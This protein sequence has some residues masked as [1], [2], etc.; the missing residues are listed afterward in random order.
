[1]HSLGSLFRKKYPTFAAWTKQWNVFLLV[2]LCM[3]V[4]YAG[5]E[6]LRR[7]AFELHGPENYD[8]SM[9]WAVGRGIVNGL[10]PYADLF[11]TKPPGIFLLSALSLSLFDSRILGSIV[12]AISL[13]IIAL[14]P[15]FAIVPPA[16][17]RR[18]PN[19]A[20]RALVSLLFGC[21]LL[22]FVAER[23]G[24]YQVESFATAWAMLF[25]LIIGNTQRP[26]TWRRIVLASLCLL[27]SVGF[28][29]QL[30]LSIL[31][32]AIVL[33][34]SWNTFFRAF[35]LPFLLAAVIGLCALWALGYTW[36]FF[37]IY[38]PEMLGR[39]IHSDGFFLLKAFR[40]EKILA[41]MTN[42][43]SFNFFFA[44]SMAYLILLSLIHP[45]IHCPKAWQSWQFLLR[46]LL[47]IL[48]SIGGVYLGGK[49]FFPHHYTVIVP[50]LFC[51]FLLVAQKWNVSLPSPYLQVLWLP[52]VVLLLLATTAIRHPDYEKALKKNREWTAPGKAMAATVDT[53]LTACKTERYLYIGLHGPKLF[54]Y[55]THSPL[56]PLFYQ[57]THYLSPERASFRSAFHQSLERAQ[58]L[59]LSKEKRE[60]NDMDGE[61]MDHIKEHFTTTPWTCAGGD[62]KSNDLYE[63]YF[64]QQKKSQ[65][66]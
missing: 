55:T 31:A 57:F 48:L 17:W 42:L 36:P 39:H 41:I 29:E 66:L 47:G 18:N 25:I 27:F 28:K 33:S 62:I 6:V 38:L 50:M 49:L 37:G 34:P 64:R 26:F 20:F 4:S 11:E 35:L 51:L 2:P 9:Y 15:L 65:N 10:V 16:E 24:E 3:A 7:L 1:M 21:L 58:I 22:L 12:Q 56:G 45:L 63:V 61:V 32:A 43:R 40:I 54:G 53:I 8:A 46:L 59:I 14:T 5:F 13:G 60:L 23:S 19:T 52:L 44:L 30:F